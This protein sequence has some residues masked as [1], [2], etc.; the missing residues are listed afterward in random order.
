LIC[1]PHK[2]VVLPKALAGMT[3]DVSAA[4]SMLETAASGTDTNTNPDS[5]QSEGGNSGD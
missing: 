4:D 1:I 3:V 2:K 5:G